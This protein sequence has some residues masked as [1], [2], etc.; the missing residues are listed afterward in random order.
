MTHT[1]GTILRGEA[2]V[3]L[4]KKRRHCPLDSWTPRVLSQWG[5]QGRQSIPSCR[6]RPVAVHEQRVLQVG[7]ASGATAE[8][9][10]VEQSRSLTVIT[11][12]APTR[13]PK[14]RPPF[15]KLLQPDVPA[16]GHKMLCRKEPPLRVYSLKPPDNP[17]MWIR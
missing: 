4:K 7:G 2:S 3:T 1:E 15:Q 14:R 16:N 10:G 17:E 6:P 12:Q 8:G 11:L 9:S 5:R 13:H